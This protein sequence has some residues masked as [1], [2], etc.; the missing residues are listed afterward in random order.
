MDNKNYQYL[1][2][3]KTKRR[4]EDTLLLKKG[5]V[6]CG[7]GLDK[8][9][10]LGIVIYSSG[11]AHGIPPK[12]DDINV[13]TEEIKP[14]EKW[15][16]EGHITAAPRQ[17]LGKG[18]RDEKLTKLRLPNKV[19]AAVA[20]PD[21]LDLVVPEILGLGIPKGTRQAYP[22][23]RVRKSGCTTG[24]SDGVVL[25]CDI[26]VFIDYSSMGY[27][28]ALFVE[29]IATT[30]MSEPGDS[31]SLTVDTD[32]YAIG[33]LFAQTTTSTFHNT[34]QNVLDAL[35][36]EI[37]V[38]KLTSE[39]RTEIVETNRE[40][41]NG[42]KRTEKWRPAPMGVSIGH[43]KGGTGTSGCL[44]T[45]KRTGEVLILSNAHVLAMPIIKK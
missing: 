7:V 36:I 25:A 41:R 18:T 15:T 19:D 26:S 22:G 23:M 31:G 35:N 3:I 33:L 28:T 42:K 30:P 4:Y 29:Q 12:L 34:I 44:V 43:Y 8:E 17:D 21:S 45:H 20:K 39:W 38:N 32:L 10:K 14:D 24:V 13:F 9:G 40:Y 27:G 6:G 16:K 5:V 2:A 1:E 37:W 11:E